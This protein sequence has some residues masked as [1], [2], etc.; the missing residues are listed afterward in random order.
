MA[1]RIINQLMVSFYSVSLDPLFSTFY[2]Q[3]MSWVSS[4]QTAVSPVLWFLFIESICWLH[5]DFRRNGLSVLMVICSTAQT[6]VAM[7]FAQFSGV[8]LEAFVDIKIKFLLSEIRFF[9]FL[10]RQ[11]FCLLNIASLSQ[12]FE[13][14]FNSY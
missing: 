2:N 13:C 1:T 6:A 11:I 14:L 5:R 7:L 9:Y 8:H 3:K 10:I 12:Y 4:S